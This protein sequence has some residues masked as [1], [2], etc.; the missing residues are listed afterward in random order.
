[1]LG[2]RLVHD[3]HARV[4]AKQFDEGPGH[5]TLI[6]VYDRHERP[7]RIGALAASQGKDRDHCDGC[8]K[9]EDERTGVTQEKTKILEEDRNHAQRPLA[10]HLTLSHDGV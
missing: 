10:G 3:R 9:G 5:R 6:L 2:S 7:R 1:M 8:E 4:L